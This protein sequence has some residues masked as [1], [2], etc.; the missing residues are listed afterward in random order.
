MH[1]ESI[2][3]HNVKGFEDVHLDLRREDG[4]LAGWTV[5][6]GRN[7]SGKSTLLKCLALAL[8]GPEHSYRLEPSMRNWVRR[9]AKSGKIELRIRLDAGCD[10][11]TDSDLS[12]TA[13]LG[14]KL[15]REG[16]W[17]KLEPINA[18]FGEKGPWGAGAGSGWLLAGY[19]PHRSLKIHAADPGDQRDAPPAVKSVATLFRENALLADSEQWLQDLH[20]RHLEIKDSGQE[21]PPLLE[22]AL[23]LLSDGL[24][25]D[26]VI[27]KRVDSEG[28]WVEQ[29]GHTVLLEETSDGYRSITAMVADL[30]HQI[31][32]AFPGRRLCSMVDGRPTV[33]CSG[34]VLIDEAENHLH[35]A[36]EQRLGV[37]L[38]NHFP[39]I[40]FLVTTHSVFICQAADSGGL[41]RLPG[42]QDDGV[43]ERVSEDIYYTVVHGG[44]DDAVVSHL[45]GLS[46][47]HSDESE[48]LREELAR[49]EAR[50]LRGQVTEHDQ[51]ELE[52]LRARMPPGPGPEVSQILRSL[53]S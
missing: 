39:N 15:H 45:F 28:L 23:A 21:P 20:Y 6:A 10:Q 4:T 32:V 26:G 29:R 12:K 43:P 33:S 9:G 8:R 38:K 27:T 46:M 48:R 42:L 16:D 2:E 19:G 47:P 50:A 5:L 41:I 17:T 40:Q 24:L 14:L 53:R 7:G 13:R 36:W 1:I 3:I 49:L 34:I 44:A 51:Q 22:D 25:P 11:L 31:K 37:W 18:E 30:M 35:P 52:R